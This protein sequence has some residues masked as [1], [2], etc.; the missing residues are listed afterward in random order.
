MQ[1]TS[2]AKS[3]KNASRAAEASSRSHKKTEDISLKRNSRCAVDAS[4]DL[5]DGLFA[6]FVLTHFEQ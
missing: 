1:Y 5:Q 6:Y 4:V 3:Y 2:E